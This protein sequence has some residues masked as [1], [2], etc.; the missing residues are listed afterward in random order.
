MR[1]LYNFIIIIL[2]SLILITFTG[3]NQKDEITLL[4][5]KLNSE[6]SYLDSQLLGM[7]NMLNNI[8]FTNYKVIVEDT[9]QSEEGGQNSSE[10][11]GG[12]ENSTSGGESTQKIEKGTTATPNLSV[13]EASNILNENRDEIDWTT[14]KQNIE[15]IYS[16]WSIILADLYKIGVNNEDILNFSRDLEQTIISIRDENKQLSLTNLSKLYSYI[17]IY[18]DQYSDDESYKNI[19]KTKVNIMIAYSLVEED[20]WDEMTRFIAEAEKYFTINVNNE[21]LNGRTDSR[22][23]KT[24]TL[25]KELQNSLQ[26]QD[27]DVFYI[28]YKN[29][30]EE[31][32]SL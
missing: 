29:L 27:K 16:T 8:T 4:K 1:R 23:N 17:P 3:C 19:E 25:L 10:S 31:L 2:L 22:T 7:F 32:T 11:S 9:S 13:M 5:E 15:T 28:K 30:I 18:L 20:N 6:I 24:Y 14:I 21:A 26:L 12:Q